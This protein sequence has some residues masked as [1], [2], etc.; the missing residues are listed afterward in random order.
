MLLFERNKSVLVSI[1]ITMLQQDDSSVVVVSDERNAYTKFDSWEGSL[2]GI[3]NL[4]VIPPRGQVVSR[5]TGLL[6]REYCMYEDSRRLSGEEYCFLRSLSL[7]KRGGRLAIFLS[8]DIITSHSKQELR[9]LVIGSAHVDAVVSFASMRG[10][11][12]ILTRGCNVCRPTLMVHSS[13]A[14]LDAD[15]SLVSA[16]CTGGD[17]SVATNNRRDIALVPQ[18]DSVSWM[19]RA[20][21]NDSQFEFAL[22]DCKRLSDY[23][24]LVYNT[25][26][27]SYDFSTPFVENSED[28]IRSGENALRASKRDVFIRQIDVVETGNLLLSRR[29][30]RISA[31]VV[32]RELSGLLLDS[33]SQTYEERFGM[34][35]HSAVRLISLFFR[36][37]KYRLYV[38]RR[39]SKTAWKEDALNLLVPTVPEKTLAQLLREADRLDSKL[40]DIY[41]ESRDVLNRISKIYSRES[42]NGPLIRLS[43]I[44]IRAEDNYVSTYDKSILKNIDVRNRFF[45]PVYLEGL[46]LSSQVPKEVLRY[47]RDIDVLRYPDVLSRNFHLTALP[48]EIQRRVAFIVCDLVKR[49]KAIMRD[50]QKLLYSNPVKDIIDTQLLYAYN[51]H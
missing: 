38:S 51:P 13:N 31:N 17:V 39:L 10:N 14:N 32:P 8:D 21:L 37:N 24:K 36:S 9:R 22:D 46:L 40:K 26:T 23:V 35:N 30:S 11:I 3:E 12:V 19:P 42:D 33:D 4:V 34:M 47:S 45:D 7:L 27:L 5:L 20:I 44:L 16:Y 48:I 25:R 41:Y 29:L 15:I 43:E 50:R 1:M 6:A 49:Y 18:M 28:G 2:P